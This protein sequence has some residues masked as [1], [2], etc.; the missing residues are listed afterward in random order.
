MSPDLLSKPLTKPGPD[1]RKRDVV[2]RILVIDGHPRGDSYGAALAAAYVEGAARAEHPVRSAVLRDL[3]FDLNALAQPLEP[4]LVSLRED[5]LWSE[6]LVFVYPTWWGTMP[7]LLKGLLDRVLSPGFA[8]E[9]RPEGGWRGLLGGRSAELI[10][11]MDTPRWIYIWLLGAPGIRAMRDA[12]LGFCEIAPVSVRTLGPIHSSTAEQ[13]Q[14]WLAQVSR[15]GGDAQARFRNGWKPWVRTW[16]TAARPQF[17][18]FPWM[19]LTAGALAA[20]STSGK[21][22][23]ILPYLCAC[24]TSALMEFIT[25]LTNDLHD[26][27]S[28]RANRNAGS[29]TGGSRVLVQH[30]LAAREL[31]K[32]RQ[33]ALGLLAAF[34]MVLL[35]GTGQIAPQI[36]LLVGAGL[37]LGIGYTAPP[38]QLSYRSWGEMDVALTHSA[39]VI[40]LGYA[41]QGG[42]VTDALPW[43]FAA[44]MFFAVLPSIVLAGFPDFEADS[45]AGKRT[46]A[47]RF[48]R[49]PAAVLAVIATAVAAALFSRTAGAGVGS[50]IVVVCASIHGVALMIA[51]IRYLRAGCPRGRIDGLLVLALTFMVW[52]AVEPL[53]RF[54]HALEKAG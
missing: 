9:V 50:Q 46:L 48:G 17:Y 34:V 40:L 38:L 31:R 3:D 6:H 8:F 22:L 10:T 29:F 39:L 30:R 7:A 53:L 23:Q 32:G 43:S 33:I 49:G 2:L 44:P 52:F 18:V 37:L 11:T 14:Q 20:S 28:D 21:P 47:V 41:S 45:A 13:R 54:W 15:D 27:T 36:L 35:L 16:I 25:V 12:T 19:A 42:A 24:L 4:D 26:Q 51:I 5:V 1:A